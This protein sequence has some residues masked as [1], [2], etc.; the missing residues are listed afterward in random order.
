MRSVNDVAPTLATARLR[1]R[2]LAAD[3]VELLWPFVS[4]PA[5]RRFM[6]WAAHRHRAETA[7]FVAS[8]EKAR[9]D[10]RGTTFAV[11]AD[12]ALVGLVGLDDITDRIRAWGAEHAQLGYWIGP[13]FQ[14]RGYAT[15][16]AAAVVDF[17]FDAVGVHK[18]SS[19]ALAE[20]DRSRHVLAK[21]GFRSIGVQRAHLFGEGRWWDAVLYE[22]LADERRPGTAEG[23]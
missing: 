17:A 9:R 10:G 12:G 11:H 1:L 4:D 8:T 18:V 21:L 23:R 20:N 7:A 3:D 22:L 6:T 13:P 2:P 15:E 16:A 14:G 19:M 5:H